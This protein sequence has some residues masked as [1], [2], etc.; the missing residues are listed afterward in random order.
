MKVRD[1]ILATPGRIECPAFLELDESDWGDVI[2]IL[3]S[4]L[5]S[6]GLIVTDEV[7]SALF[8]KGVYMSERGAGHLFESEVAN[9]L[10]RK[11]KT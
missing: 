7:Y 3:D 5:K 6:M 4:V 9:R 8:E 2:A 1:Q 10:G 11:R